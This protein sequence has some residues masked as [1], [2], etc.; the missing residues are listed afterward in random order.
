MD[1]LNVRERYEY[2]ASKWKNNTITQEEQLEFFNWLNANE[3]NT[4]NIPLSFAHSE[5]ELRNIIYEQIN[6]VIIQNQKPKRLKLWQRIAAAAAVLLMAGLGIWFYTFREYNAD[7]VLTVAKNDIAPGTNK[8]TL[9]LNNGKMIPLSDAETR[10]VINSGVVRYAFSSQFSGSGN[11]HLLSAKEQLTMTTPRGGTYE[12]MLPDGTKVWLNASSILK[13]PSTFAGLNIRK[14]ELIGEAY[15]E[16][17]K[18]NKL[19]VI[20]GKSVV[21]SIPFV[22]KTDKQ[23]VEV[24]GTHFNINSYADEGSVKTTLLEGSVRVSAQNGVAVILKPNQQSVLTGYA[25]QI[26]Q[27]DMETIVDWKN[28]DFVFNGVDFK[29]AMRKIARWY[30]VEIVYDEQLPVDI[31][32]GGWISRD[33]N[34]SVVLK[35]IESSGQVHFKIE[36]RRVY[37]TR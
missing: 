37:V 32:P 5:T 34:L 33:N 31:D 9:T 4:I 26:K 8:A 19:K 25:I 3:E 14:V 21:A 17:A 18:S 36:G 22:V 28:N 15:F 24:L 23:E 12:L 20:G 29:T 1:G 35:R 7:Q 11:I 27:V 13:F 30:N 16:V 10:V 2:L 6:R